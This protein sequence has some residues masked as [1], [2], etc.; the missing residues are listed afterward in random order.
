MS[1]SADNKTVLRGTGVVSS[2]TLLSR[3][4]GFLRDLVIARVFGA[5]LLSDTFFVAFRIPNLLR[6]VVAEGALTSAFV[7]VFAGELKK[8]NVAANLALRSIISL[9]LLATT[10]FALAGIIWA[11][12]VVSAMAP[13][14]SANSGQFEL[15]VLLTRI[16]MPYIMFVSITAIL[17]G[18]LNSVQ[19]FGAGP[20]AQIVMNIATIGGAVVSAWFAQN[21][22]ILILA[23]SVIVGGIAQIAIQLP[24][25][26]RAKLSIL[27]T[28]HPA[29]RVAREVALLFIPGI[30]GAAVYQLSIF[31]NTALASLL[32][33]GGVSW[34]SYADRLA[35]LPLGVFSIALASVLLPTLS[36]AAADN[37]PERF[38]GGIVNALRYNSFIMIP[39]SLGLWFY[40][41]PLVQILFERGAFTHV[42]TIQTAAAL[43]A[44][45]FG[46]WG[47]SGYSLA[48]RGFIARKNTVTPTMIGVFSV[49]TGFLIAVVLMGPAEGD[50]TGWILS[51]VA[52]LQEFLGTRHVNALGHVGLALGS[53]L[54]S[55]ISFGLIIGILSIKHNYI[56]WTPFIL[57]TMKSLV[58]GALMIVGLM[59][60]AR[61]ELG[62]WI[63]LAVGMPL[64][65]GIYCLVSML[66]RSLELQETFKLV[67]K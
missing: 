4:L 7:P 22:A 29:S 32:S 56:R 8:G 41:V 38:A 51:I 19:V 21:T 63:E 25:L 53:G 48:I 57:A 20:M 44:Y 55:T 5:G 9:L 59:F 6:S 1:S 61:L 62:V 27:P 18:A 12:Q 50:R 45:C 54:A 13:G 47:V 11:P 43:Q 42:S 66:L 46:L 15:C 49:V 35:Q 39:V 26:G 16:M 60:F 14:F 10:V 37:S 40:A 65:V 17:N 34:L 2:L 36:S 33:H 58:A 23:W 31:V 52:P 30:V 28:L 3:F 24:A 64:G 67:R